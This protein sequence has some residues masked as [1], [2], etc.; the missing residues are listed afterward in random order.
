MY[1]KYILL[2]N[3]ISQFEKKTF[4]NNL[5]FHILQLLDVKCFSYSY[6]YSELLA[7]NRNGSIIKKRFHQ[8]T[9]FL[10]S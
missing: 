1:T 6:Y 3:A 9:A 8:D 2:L 5:C 7:K 4:V 10:N